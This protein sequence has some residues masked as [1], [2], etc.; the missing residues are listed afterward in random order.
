MKY[1][2]DYLYELGYTQNE[3]EAF[4]RQGWA[5][6]VYE[7]LSDPDMSDVRERQVRYLLQFFDKA[8]IL[9][10]MAR[11]CDAFCIGSD[12]FKRRFKQIAEQMGEDW[13][14]KLWTACIEDEESIFDAVGYMRETDWNNALEKISK[15]C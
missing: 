3:L 9:R 1:N 8:E 10:L 2:W 15:A 6:G 14:E 4:E 7:L 11:Y 12:T 5:D 13:S